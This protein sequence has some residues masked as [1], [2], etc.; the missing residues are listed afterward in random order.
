MT[1]AQWDE[2]SVKSGEVVEVLATEV[3]LVLDS[4]EAT[5]FNPTPMYVPADVNTSSNDNMRAFQAFSTICESVPSLWVIREDESDRLIEVAGYT[6]TCP[7]DYV[8]YLVPVENQDFELAT[9]TGYGIRLKGNV[10]IYGNNAIIKNISNPGYHAILNIYD[11]GTN[12][13]IHNLT[14]TGGKTY[15]GQNQ[16]GYGGAINVGEGTSLTLLDSTLVLN[17][18]QSGGGAIMNLGNLTIQRTKFLENDA[19]GGG[20]IQNDSGGQVSAECSVFENNTGNYATA[21]LNGIVSNEAGRLNVIRSTFRGNVTSTNLP[22][23]AINLLFLNDYFYEVMLNENYWGVEPIEGFDPYVGFDISTNSPLSN[24]PTIINPS[25]G[26]YDFPDC[27]AN[28]PIDINNANF[29]S[30]SNVIHPNFAVTVSSFLGQTNETADM[31]AIVNSSGLIVHDGPTWNAKHLDVLPWN[32]PIAIDR[33]VILPNGEVWFRLSNYYEGYN[34]GW[35]AGW[36]TDSEANEGGYS[37]LEGVEASGGIYANVPL[38]GLAE[39]ITFTYDRQAAAEYAMAHAYRN[40]IPQSISG[41]VFPSSVNVTLRI[42]P[43][44]NIDGVPIPYAQEIPYAVFPYSEISGQAKATGSAVFLA[45]AIWMG[46]LPMTN[47][48]DANRV[49]I[50]MDCGSSISITLSGWRYCN[51]ENNS[52]TGNSTKV[53]SNHQGIIC[54]LSSSTES[55]P[56]DSVLGEWRG[57]SCDFNNPVPVSSSIDIQKYNIVLDP[58]QHGQY[59]GTFQIFVLQDDGFV[60]RSEITNALGNLRDKGGPVLDENPSIFYNNFIVN[61]QNESP[62][63]IPNITNLQT[64]DY[65]FSG[66]GYTASWGHGYLIAGWGPISSC[67]TALSKVWSLEILPNALFLDHTSAVANYT[68]AVPYVVDFPGSVDSDKQTQRPRPRPFY[69]INYN[70]PVTM[71]YQINDNGLSFHSLPSVVSIPFK[72][73]YTSDIWAWQPGE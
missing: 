44:L 68:Y 9:D 49:A 39:Y 16:S 22:S 73:L 58:S 56:I 17:N 67:P 59:L 66:Q 38:L 18:A 60:T 41:E 3:P 51:K 27:T 8:I 53:W 13:T 45:Q 46:G 47:N 5:S 31:K 72:N 29:N 7:Q 26:V 1:R 4:A 19:G 57:F 64:G 48:V 21:I 54:Y 43:A 20:A 6:A 10:I 35:V 42:N 65:A 70:D 37:Y 15:A 55:S 12:V 33:K 30:C 25:T 63:I 14:L 36:V 2:M 61:T 52:Q 11:S 28:S 71:K 40:S 62:Y 50:N 34:D 24:N 32:Y 23:N 69:C